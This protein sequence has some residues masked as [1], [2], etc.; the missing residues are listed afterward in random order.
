[1]N[2]KMLLIFV[3]SLMT[4]ALFAQYPV[5]WTD[6]SLIDPANDV[7][8]SLAY[9]R[10]TDHVLVATRYRGV[11]VI[12]LDAA[13]GD[14]LGKLNTDGVEGGTYPI[15]M[16]SVADDGTIY[17]CNLS[18]P[19]Y[20][21]GSKF[22]VYR[23]ADENAMPELIFEDALE[24][25]RFGDSFAAVGEGSNKYIYSSGQGQNTLAVIK[26][27]GSATATLEGLIALPQP[28]AAR[29]GISA[30]SPGGKLWIN[31][32]DDGSPP[33]QLINSDGTVIAVIP[34]SLAS[35]GGTS[36]ITHMILGEYNLITVS[37]AWSMSIR[38]VQYFEDELGTV[39]FDYFGADSD[40]L[41][42]LYNGNTFNTN[43]NASTSLD[44]DSKRHC[45]VSLFGYNSVSSLSLDS[46]LKASTPR[47]GDLTI[48]V[49]GNNDFFPTD[50]VGS[51]NGRDMYFTWSEGKLFFGITGHTL[52]DPTETNRMY[53]AFD[54]DPDGGNGSTT[55]P[56]EAG[57]VQELPFKAD[58]VYMVEPWQEADYLIGS[59]YKWNGSAWAEGLFDGNMASQGALAYAAEGERKLA[60][61]SAIMNADGIGAG[62]TS[63]GIMAYV[64]EKDASGDVLCAFP[65]GNPIGNGVSFG[66]YFY[67]DSL[68]KGMFPTDTKYVQVKGT[69][70]SVAVDN[71][72]NVPA[73]YVLDQNY[74]NPFNP[75]TT[76]QYALSKSVNVNLNVYD[77]TG[78][79]VATL[80]NK[81]Q[82]AGNH[83]VV[84]SGENL[85]SGVYFYKL[86]AGNET[87]ATK[88]M[89]LIK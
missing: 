21:P 30:V 29:H 6:Y 24:N 47:E 16:V 83:R 25:G 4:S 9:N 38:S 8:R 75:K 72:T 62:F 63:I 88:K 1:M 44:Y 84:F 48:S 5:N 36:C 77:I 27:H 2:K 42:L 7:T 23:Y 26:D 56:E 51:S 20:S 59:I 54:L 85:S 68:G 89:I 19:Q 50:H 58:V 52:V 69:P 40:S 74:P 28:G 43:F 31:G 55:P 71:T 53:V 61:L 60:E 45:M 41:P 73:E 82:D 35:P 70:S 76:I 49:D 18:A 17:V 80:V 87:V 3:L 22:K 13:S 10:S 11:D 14:S 37:N 32:A 33:P 34:D 46:L 65:D 57:G 39:L 79:K 64:A 67:A 81:K 15:N 12:V 86:T 78:R 66:Q